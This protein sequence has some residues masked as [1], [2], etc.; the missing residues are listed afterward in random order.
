[1]HTRCRLLVK[2]ESKRRTIQDGAP[3]PESLSRICERRMV[4]KALLKSTKT[5]FRT[6]EPPSSDY[7]IVCA[8][9]PTASKVL[10]AF[11]YANWFWSLDFS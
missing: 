9:R 6:F 4:L 5:V 8:R 11:L 10:L 3:R 2:K 1:M 7:A